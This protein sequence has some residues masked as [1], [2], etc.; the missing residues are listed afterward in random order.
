MRRIIRTLIYGTSIGA[1]A[2]IVREIVRYI[3]SNM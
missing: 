2:Q 1:G 3:Q